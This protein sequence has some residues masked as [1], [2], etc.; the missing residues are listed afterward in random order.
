M[1]R[2]GVGFLPRRG[3]A[4]G[5]VPRQQAFNSALDSL[6]SPFLPSL[7]PRDFGCS[8]Q[9]SCWR[10]FRSVQPSRRRTTATDNWYAG[11]A[12]A[13][14]GVNFT[15]SDNFIFATLF[16]YGSEQPRGQPTWY[17]AQMTWDGQSQ[18]VGGLYRTEG[19]YFANPWNPANSTNVQV[20]V[21]SF[22]PSTLNN[23]EGTFSYTVNGVPTVTKAVTRLTLTPILLTANYVGGQSGSY[24]GSHRERVEPDV[25]GFL[26]PGR[27]PIGHGRDPVVYVYGFQ[28]AVDMLHRGHDD[29]ERVDL[30]HREC[31]L[32]V[33]RRPQCE[34]V[35]LRLARHPAGHRR[36]VYGT[37]GGW[38][39]PRNR[40]V[41]R[42]AQLTA[43]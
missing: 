13:G 42:D 24:T 3:C 15:Q 29:P 2:Q 5:A 36:A 35:G 14:W 19:T 34:R 18:F 27:V 30:P 25:P 12:E 41:R 8:L 6:M 23:Y 21:A 31:H 1:V 10:R 7:S 40:E 32:S 16:I 43:R 39:L 20:G 33:F 22:T 4:H 17:Y 38:W 37:Y 28:S 9:A 11:S 26:Q